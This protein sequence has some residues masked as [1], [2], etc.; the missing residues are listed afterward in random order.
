[1]AGTFSMLRANDLVWSFVINNYLMGKDPFPFDLLYWNSD[2]TR[3]PRAMHSFYLR[4]MYL[5]NILKEPGG[6]TLGGV[7]IDI[8]KVKTPCYFVSAIE[9][10][11]AP[12]ISTYMGVHLPS[13]PVNFVLGGSGHIA[14]IVNPPAGN[15]YCYWTNAKLPETA[16]QWFEGAT[17]HEGSWWPNWEQWVEAIDDKKVA[18]RVPGDGPLKAIEDAP[19][20]FVKMRADAKKAP[21]VAKPKAKAAK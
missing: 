11:I 4:N 21:A 20:S 9:D 17:Q 16:Q 13:G 14:G 19:G 15:K 5:K 12:W 2:S 8:R 10:H 6:I 18:A 3:M 7:P 1:M